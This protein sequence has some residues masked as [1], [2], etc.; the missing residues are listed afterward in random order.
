MFGR[1]GLRRSEVPGGITALSCSQSGTT[2]LYAFTGT[3][4]A[5]GEITIYYTTSLPSEPVATCIT[6]TATSCL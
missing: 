4:A 6:V 3:L 2:I 1:G 5:G